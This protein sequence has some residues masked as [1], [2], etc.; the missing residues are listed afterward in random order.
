MDQRH[1]LSIKC[2]GL[3]L[4]SHY[5]LRVSNMLFILNS[6]GLTFFGVIVEYM[7]VGSKLGREDMCIVV[8]GLHWFY[9]L[10]RHIW[11]QIS[12][13]E[14]RDEWIRYCRFYQSICL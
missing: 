9:L 3:W 4:S 10:G 12:I 11:V 13:C 2:F 1:G 6:N 7:G 8:G 5:G 14:L